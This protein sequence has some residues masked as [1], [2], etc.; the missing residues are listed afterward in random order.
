VNYAWLGALPHPQTRLKIQRAHVLVHA[1]KMEGGA[2]VVMEA[3]C[4]GTPVIASDIS[5]NVGMLG[6]D[7]LGYFPVGDA[8][9][10]ALLLERCKDESQFIDTLRAQCA[11]RAPLFAP[12]AE[13]TALLQVIQSL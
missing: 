11:L 13:L 10:L 6:E 8:A 3:V 2:H 5:G 7:Y 1:S 4:S 12:Q 9:A